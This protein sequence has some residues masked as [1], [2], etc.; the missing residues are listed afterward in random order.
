MTAPVSPQWEPRD[1]FSMVVWAA[2][3]APRAAREL[4]VSRQWL[5]GECAGEIALALPKLAG[6]WE[7]EKTAQLVGARGFWN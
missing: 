7:R 1:G 4:G 6:L 3:H 5:R 2:F